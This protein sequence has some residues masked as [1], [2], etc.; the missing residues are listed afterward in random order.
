MTVM[1]LGKTFPANDNGVDNGD[2]DGEDAM[3]AV[4]VLPAAASASELTNDT[5]VSGDGGVA[6]V[7]SGDIDVVHRFLPE[8]GGAPDAIVGGGSWAGLVWYLQRRFA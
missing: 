6:A 2:E 7:A 3:D 5:P 1:S 4:P 8:G